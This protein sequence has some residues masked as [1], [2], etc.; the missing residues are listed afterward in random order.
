MTEIQ[1]NA[2][3]K[4]VLRAMYDATRGEAGDTGHDDESLV[5][6]TGLKAEEVFHAT[7]RL[8]EL[9]FISRI[10]KLG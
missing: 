2:A 1:L 6:V 7:Y 5:R 9:G 3:E 4:K 8:M 10:G